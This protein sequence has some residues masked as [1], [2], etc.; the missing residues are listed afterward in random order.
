MDLDTAFNRFCEGALPYG[1]FW[2]HCLE[3]WKESIAR[4]D[5]VL[6]LK[7]EDMMPDPVRCVKNL[8]LALFV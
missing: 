7:Y 3:Y 6:F 2:N 1:P 8:A 4:P 5:R